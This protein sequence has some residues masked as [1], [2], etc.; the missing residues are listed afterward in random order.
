MT[1]TV[2]LTKD[3]ARRL[4]HVTRAQAAPEN[5]GPYNATL[6]NCYVGEEATVATD[7]MRLHATSTPYAI[8]MRGEMLARFQSVQSGGGSIELKPAKEKPADYPD[9]TS[10]MPE[11]P[12]SAEVLIDSRY[13]SDAIAAAK[14]GPV[15]LVVYPQSEEP[16]RPP[17]IEVYAQAPD[18]EPL[19]SIVAG[20]VPFGP[21]PNW[22]P[23]IPPK[24]TTGGEPGA[25]SIRAVSTNAP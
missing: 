4:R 24:G 2:K 16:Y 15:R 25:A 20:M 7:G 18:G 21:P 5:V 1:D 6:V 23:S 8:A 14:P 17:I 22:R 9:L 12:P 13:L 19:Y 3:E 11:I 10:A